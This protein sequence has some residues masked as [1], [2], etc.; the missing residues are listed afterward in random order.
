M[1]ARI[2]DK[3][4]HPYG[5]LSMLSGIHV[6]FVHLRRTNLMFIYGHRKNK[7]IVTENKTLCA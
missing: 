6:C 2:C 7:T 3:C 1:H 4:D 5:F